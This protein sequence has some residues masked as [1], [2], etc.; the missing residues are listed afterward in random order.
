MPASPLTKP[1][2]TLPCLLRANH[3]ALLAAAAAVLFAAAPALAGPEEIQVYMNELDAP[4]EIGLD[5]HSNYVLSGDR[6]GD[7]LG[8]QQSVHRL[9]IT[10]EFSYGLTNNLELGAYLPLATL[11]GHGRFGLDGV[12]FRLKYILPR[13]AGQKW[14]VGANF[15][16]GKV[17]H[18]L[19]INPY[20][21]EFKGIA[22]V[23]FGKWTAAANA[24]VDFTVS[25]PAPGPASLEIATKL[26]Y[27]LSPKFALGVEN[28]T[29]AGEFRALGHFSSSE[30]TSYVTI[31]ASIGRWD[32]NLG[33]GRGYGANP[34]KW[35]VK[36]VIGVPIG[37]KR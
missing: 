31:D 21:A 5:I 35:I 10:P 12:K 2:A 33:V 4:G 3:I 34:D 8:E 19:D 15:E 32:L 1:S 11:D 28:Y 13:A 24:N 25:G 18:K 36:A 7:Y 6:V 17:N 16:I 26:N 20:N 30:Q 22:G 27:A 23:R 29:G 14:F 37:R 9:R